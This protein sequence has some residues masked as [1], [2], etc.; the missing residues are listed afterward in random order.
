MFDRYNKSEPFSHLL[1]DDFLSLPL[2]KSINDEFWDFKDPKWD[3]FGSMFYNKNAQKKQMYELEKMPPSIQQFY[4]LCTSRDFLDSLSKMSR[5]NVDKYS[6]F[7]AGMNV[8][9]DNAELKAHTDF[10]FNNDIKAYRCLNLLLYLCDDWTEEHGGCL[11]LFSGDFKKSIDIA[12]LSNRLVI[13]P[14]N[15]K[16]PHGVSRVASGVQRR[17][18]S[19]YYYSVECP[20]NISK[21][22]HR[23]IWKKNE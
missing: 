2:I 23:T 5:L 6:L 10:N 13:F 7:G 22:P 20:P 11:Q 3:K 12:P 17:S 8:Y 18:L 15:D 9:G 16:T 21:Q 14:T 19:L 4:S 1:V